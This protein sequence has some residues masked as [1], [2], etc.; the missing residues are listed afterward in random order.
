MCAT[1]KNFY[2]LNHVAQTK[3]QQLLKFARMVILFG[4]AD[5][6]ELLAKENMISIKKFLVRP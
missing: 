3:T 2:Q 1:G 6:S 5:L 4:T